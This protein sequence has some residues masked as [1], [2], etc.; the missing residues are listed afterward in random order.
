MPK[1]IQIRHVPD[2]LHRRLKSRA[3]ASG[4]SLSDFLRHELERVSEQLTADEV[5]E[6]LAG[7][8]PAGGG[9]S[10]VHAVRAEREARARR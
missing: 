1:M 4:M 5:R 10:S 8:E 3:A 7:L 6:R 9:E 2:R